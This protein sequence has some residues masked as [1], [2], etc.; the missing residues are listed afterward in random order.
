MKHKTTLRMGVVIIAAAA[1]AFALSTSAG[2]G[3][4]TGPNR[5]RAS[6]IAYATPWTARRTSTR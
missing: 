2:A 6:H 5:A 1:A 3:P 4:V